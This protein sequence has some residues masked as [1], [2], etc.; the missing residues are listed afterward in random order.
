MNTKVKLAMGILFGAT[1]IAP[2]I[3]IADAPGGSV[4]PH[5]HYVV[6][7]GNGLV[8]TGPNACQN[9]SSLQFDNFHNH[10]HQGQPGLNGVIVGLPCP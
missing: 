4:P 6:S 3:A 9:G 7:E 10:G 2:A 5:Q 1:A 8:P